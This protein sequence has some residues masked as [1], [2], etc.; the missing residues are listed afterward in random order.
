MCR[1]GDIIAR[2][3]DCQDRVVVG[4]MAPLQGSRSSAAARRNAKLGR[5][6]QLPRVS[7]ANSC[8][9]SKRPL[10]RT[11]AESAIAVVT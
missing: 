3:F 2:G 6:V 11:W 8:E 1:E 5:F 9:R 4:V 7:S 10:R